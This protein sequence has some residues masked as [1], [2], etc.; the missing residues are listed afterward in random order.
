LNQLEPAQPGYFNQPFSTAT[1][2]KP[3]PRSF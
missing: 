3:R 2:A 1:A